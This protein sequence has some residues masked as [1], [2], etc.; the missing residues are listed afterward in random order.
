[1]AAAAAPFRISMLSMSFGFN[2]ALF[3]GVVLY[4]VAA[5]VH[6]TGSARLSS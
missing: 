6:L 4:L 3:V 2:A 5:T 1:M